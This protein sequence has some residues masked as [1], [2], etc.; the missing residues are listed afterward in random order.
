MWQL[1]ILYRCHAGKNLEPFRRPAVSQSLP[2]GSRSHLNDTSVVRIWKKKVAALLP[3]EGVNKSK[4]QTKHNKTNNDQ[5]LDDLAVLLQ[6]KPQGNLICH[7]IVRQVHVPT[8]VVTAHDPPSTA[9]ALVVKA[10]EIA[11]TPIPVGLG[12]ARLT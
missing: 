12:G 9:A 10:M 3:I 8:I 6:E 11:G 7:A 2:R 5:K 4:K 1:R